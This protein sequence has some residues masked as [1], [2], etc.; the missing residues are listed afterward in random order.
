VTLLPVTRAGDGPPIVLLHAGIADRSMWDEH[1]APLAAAGFHA[2]ALDLP[3]FGDAPLRAGLQTP[4]IDVLETLD[5]LGVGQTIL[6]GNSF[7]G[8]IALRAAIM[9]PARFTHLVLVS[10]PPL[11]GEPSPALSAAWD[12]EEG[13]LARGDL[14]AAVEAV[15]D[16]WVLPDASPALR[17]KVGAMQRRAFALQ[18]QA[19]PAVEA[20]D[21][22]AQPGATARLTMPT[23]MIVGAH[24]FVDFAATDAVLAGIPHRRREVISQAGHLAPLETPEMFR[25]LVLAFVAA[26]AT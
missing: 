17:D 25:D 8:A 9:D 11:E 20:I 19:P 22:A 24:D 13:A 6:V 7:G 14:D 4:W 5:G 18:A 21:P 3:G 23:L 12:A 15:L 26:P 10:P 16:A 1:L 2:I